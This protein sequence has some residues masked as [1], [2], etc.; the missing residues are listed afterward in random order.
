MQPIQDYPN[1]TSLR[2]HIREAARDCLRSWEAPVYRAVDLKWAKPADLLSG[3]G[4]FL[5]GS[6]W[7]RPGKAHVFYGASTEA[8]ALKE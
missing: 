1:T 4:A 7:M 5:N 3:R 2:A 6:R 8:L